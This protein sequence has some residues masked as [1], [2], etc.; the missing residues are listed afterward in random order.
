MQIWKFVKI[1]SEMLCAICFRKM[2]TFLLFFF[3]FKS[4]QETICIYGFSTDLY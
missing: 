1:D 2:F 3:I 4:D